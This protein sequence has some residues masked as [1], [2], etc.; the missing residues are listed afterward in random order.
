MSNLTF[1]LDN[2][3]GIAL[4]AHSENFQVA[5]YGLLCFRVA[6]HFDAE[7]VAVVLPVEFALH[8]VVSRS[9]DNTEHERFTSETLKR[10][11]WRR[12]SLLGNPS[13]VTRAG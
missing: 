3:H 11:V 6:I 10:L 7:E 12:I 2:L 4:L 9:N 13:R 1:Q 5:E 8:F